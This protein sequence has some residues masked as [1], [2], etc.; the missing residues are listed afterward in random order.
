MTE[1]E[2]IVVRQRIHL[3]D[4]LYRADKEA[5]YSELND[6]VLLYRIQNELNTE[7]E[8]NSDDDDEDLTASGASSR[9]NSPRKE[10]QDSYM[11]TSP[12]RFHI[13][14]KGIDAKRFPHV[15]SYNLENRSKKEIKQLFAAANKKAE[16]MA[17]SV[18]M[19]RLR[20]AEDS[21]DIDLSIDQS[22]RVEHYK[23][24]ELFHLELRPSPSTREDDTA[25]DDATTE[26][27]EAHHETFSLSSPAAKIIERKREAADVLLMNQLESE[28]LP[29]RL[30]KDNEKI[31]KA[32]LAEGIA[33]NF[34]VDPSRH[35]V[36]LTNYGIGDVQGGNLGRA[37]K[38]LKQLGK[39]LLKENRLTWKC[40]PVIFANLS[41]KSLFHIDLSHNNLKG[42]QCSTAISEYFTRSQMCAKCLSCLTAT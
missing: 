15:A 36:D 35:T 13:T 30:L 18:H 25:R 5:N 29:E 10:A 16:N 12:E 8:M 2:E 21:K 32:Q 20:R 34:R 17:D 4:V 22:R 7:Q 6:G 38:G 3:S 23:Q 11:Y 31:T 33:S 9:S 39:L 28:T 26:H 40:I 1:E 42:G 41:T 37:I 14:K 19:R 24:L 27:E